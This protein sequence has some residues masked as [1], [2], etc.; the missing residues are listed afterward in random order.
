M[1]SKLR[2]PLPMLLDIVIPVVGYYVLSACGLD[3]FWALTISGSVTAVNALVNT[4]RRGRLDA[5]GTLVVLEIALSVALFFVTRDPRTVLLKPSF[6]TALAAAFLF[7][8]CLAGRPFT[9]ETTEPFATRGHP[10]LA[11]AYDAAATGNGGL[12]REH[13]LIPAVW[14]VLWLVESVVRA[15]VVLQSSIADGVLLS[16]LPGIAVIVLGIVFTKMRVPAMKRLVQ[17]QIPVAA[18][19]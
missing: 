10:E 16:Q 2:A 7:C 6:Y 19:R 15:V 11:E 9:L 5:L 4:V 8:T 17:A 18:A 3:D 1:N 14:G 13:V 12:R